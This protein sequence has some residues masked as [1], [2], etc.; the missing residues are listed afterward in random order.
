MKFTNETIIKIMQLCED[1]SNLSVREQEDWFKKASTEECGNAIIGGYLTTFLG[2]AEENGIILDLTYSTMKN[3]SAGLTALYMK[4]QK[5]NYGSKRNAI[6]VGKTISVY[7]T[8]LC[9]NEEGSKLEYENGNSP[10]LTQEA[11]A[12][13]HSKSYAGISVSTGTERIINFFDAGQRCVFGHDMEVEGGLF[14]AM[15]PAIR[16]YKRATGVDLA[17]YGLMDTVI[18]GVNK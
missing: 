3:F 7:L 18:S 9:V 2:V 10:L 6:V 11:A 1:N 12:E 13:L 15:T 14:V 17:E 16:A 4:Q 8:L 5:L